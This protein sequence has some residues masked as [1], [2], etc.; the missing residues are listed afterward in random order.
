[1]MHFMRLSLRKGAHPA[2]SGVAWLEIRVG[3]TKGRVGTAP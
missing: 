1:L 2:L 3:M